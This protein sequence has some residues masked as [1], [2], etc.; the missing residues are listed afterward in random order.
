MA[1]GIKSCATRTRGVSMTDESDLA[2]AVLQELLAQ[3]TAP[4]HEGRVGAR[5][6]AYA[7]EWGLPVQRDETGN[8]IVRYRRGPACRPLIL[9]AHMDHPGCSIVAPGGPHGADWTAVLEGGVA[10]AYFERPVAVRLYPRAQGMA[11]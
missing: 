4:F 11:A 3:P 7:H 2:L 1:R 8:I 10:D 5:V 6:R 9:M